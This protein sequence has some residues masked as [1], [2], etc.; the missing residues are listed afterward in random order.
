[1]RILALACLLPLAAFAGDA[2]SHVDADLDGDGVLDTATLTASDGYAD[3][4]IVSSRDGAITM[5]NAAWMGAA[6]GTIPELEMTDRGSLILH[7]MNEAVGRNRWHQLLTIAYRDEAFRVAGFTYGWYDTLNPE[8]NGLCDLNLLT[9]IGELSIGPEGTPA[10][11]IEV[12]SVSA[13]PIT[14]WED[15]Y[16]P[17]CRAE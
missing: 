16:P 15:I 13:V 2:L 5:A 3:L 9:G 4:L 8:A 17:E 11:A 6:A 14:E 12:Y 1:M 7:S 10:T